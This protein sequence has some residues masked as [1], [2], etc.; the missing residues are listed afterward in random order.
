[1]D[2][3]DKL[4]EYKMTEIILSLIKDKSL[5]SKNHKE[6]EQAKSYLRANCGIIYINV[7]KSI[8]NVYQVMARTKTTTLVYEYNSITEELI[9][10]GERRNVIS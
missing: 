8:N 3:I 1:M 6:V 7:M 9:I 2:I 10:K 4:S 5:T